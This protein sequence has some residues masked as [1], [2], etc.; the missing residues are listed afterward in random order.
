MVGFINEKQ[1]MKMKWNM[2][3]RTLMNPIDFSLLIRNALEIG[4]FG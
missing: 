4:S 3:A 1:N 2:I